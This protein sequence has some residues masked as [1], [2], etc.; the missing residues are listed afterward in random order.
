MPKHRRGPKGDIQVIKVMRNHSPH[1]ALKSRR[2]L[3]QNEP[4]KVYGLMRPKLTDGDT[5]AIAVSRV[6]VTGGNCR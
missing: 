4:Y 5:R 3:P 6:R 2:K 1:P